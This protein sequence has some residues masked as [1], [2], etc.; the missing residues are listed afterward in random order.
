VRYSNRR[1]GKS[2]ARFAWRPPS[3]GR[4]DDGP[5]RTPNPTVALSSLIAFNVIPATLRVALAFGAGLVILSRI[6]WHVTSAV[7]DCERLITGTK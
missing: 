3:Q 7:F 6:G 4:G 2:E 5:R 1:L